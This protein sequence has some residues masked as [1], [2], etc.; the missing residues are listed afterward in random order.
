MRAGLLLLVLDFLFA[1]GG[2]GQLTDTGLTGRPGTAII[3]DCHAVGVLGLPYEHACATTVHWSDGLVEQRS[4]DTADLGPGDRGREFPVVERFDRD[5][6]GLGRPVAELDTPSRY[7]AL[8]WSLLVSVGGV[9]AFFPFWI[10]R[11]SPGERAERRARARVRPRPAL[12]MAT[13]YWLIVTGALG[14]PV[15]PPVAGLSS[16]GPLVWPPL[17]VV[18]LGHVVLLTGLVLARYRQVKGWPPV[19]DESSGP[20]RPIAAVVLVLLA[21]PGV[22][23]LLGSATAD[24]AVVAIRLALPV[25]LVAVAVRLLVVWFRLRLKDS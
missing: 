12:G 7:R 25:T 10:R 14:F 8:A 23:G 2:S 4:F 13:G 18:L 1:A 3:Q 6:S 5:K 24:P 15:H 9:A 20:A 22:L 21:L 16:W 17:V 19:P 11:R